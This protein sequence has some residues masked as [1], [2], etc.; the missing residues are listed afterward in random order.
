MYYTKKAYDPA[1]A[2]RKAKNEQIFKETTADIQRGGYK[3][4]SG[5]AWTLDTSLI[6]EGSRCYHDE[7]PP[8]PGDR[9]PGGTKIVVL[10]EDCL[11]TAERLVGRDYNPALLNFASGGHPGGGV[12]RGS[13]AQEET[14]CRRSTLTRS[15]Y[16]FDANYAKRFGYPH[17]EGANYPLDNLDFSAIYSPGVTVFREG[18]ECTYMEHPYSVA[19]ITCAA[20]NLNGTHRLKLTPD[21]R[22]PEEAVAITRNKVRTIFRIALLHGHDSLVLGAFGCGA[23][24][25]PPEQVAAIFHEVLE[26]AEFKDRFRIVTFSIIEDH[27]SKNRNLYAFQQEFSNTGHP[28]K[29]PAPDVITRLSNN[30]V[31]VFGSNLQGAHAGGAAHAAVVSFGAVWGQGVGLQGQSYAIPTMQGPVETIKPYVDEFTRFAAEHPELEFL[32]TRIGCGIAGF[33]DYQIAPLFKDALVLDNVRLPQSFLQL[34]Q[35]K[36]TTVPTL[37]RT[38]HKEKLAE[39]VERMRHIGM[40][41][42]FIKA[43]EHGEIMI[44]DP[45]EEPYL[46]GDRENKEIQQLEK[47]YG[48]LV[49]GVLHDNEYNEDWVD[50]DPV[51]VYLFV[52]DNPEK[53]QEEREALYAM[54][55]I[56]YVSFAN[57]A[58][59]DGFCSPESAITIHKNGY[60]VL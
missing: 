5:H 3:T 45:D 15:I 32:V 55:P 58:D 49:W 19:F 54:K 41:E 20:L 11:V 26:E 22:M 25:N 13:R 46:I 40:D 14:I 33:K 8:V 12:E 56:V 53:W 16:T 27:N 47:R 51:N 38:T 23:F 31:F 1:I 9:V 35:K 28:K 60:P 30:Q 4:P 24:K 39:A 43:L 2:E 44:Y 48:I 57:P 34:L 59:V 52:W 18:K 50:G 42:E 37:D 17:H 36:E 10:G 21:K 7:L 6:D 29:Q